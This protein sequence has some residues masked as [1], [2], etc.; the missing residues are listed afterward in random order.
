MFHLEHGLVSPDDL[1]DVLSPPVF[2]LRHNKTF[3]AVFQS[4]STVLS[5]PLS[6]SLGDRELVPQKNTLRQMLIYPEEFGYHN[7]NA[8][9]LLKAVLTPHSYGHLAHS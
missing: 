4:F 1:I 6:L 7:R 3:F 9:I 2:K 5:P 8:F